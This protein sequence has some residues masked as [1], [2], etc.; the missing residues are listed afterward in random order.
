MR[1]SLIAF[2]LSLVCSGGSLHAQH[3]MG[4][5]GL[6]GQTGKS[7]IKIT[8]VDKKNNQIWLKE[9]GVSATGWPM[10]RVKEMVLLS[11]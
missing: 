3:L 7:D 4:P 11:A 1:Y 8:K 6:T 5:T 9:K 10:Q 2:L